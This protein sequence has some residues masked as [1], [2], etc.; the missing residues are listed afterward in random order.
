MAP[1]RNGARVCG[2]V[3]VHTCARGLCPSMSP[4]PLSRRTSC[5]PSAGRP[6]P[7]RSLTLRWPAGVAERSGVDAPSTGVAADRGVEGT[8]V[9]PVSVSGAVPAA[10]APAGCCCC[11]CCGCCGGCC[12]G[13]CGCCGCCCGCCGCCAP[14]AG[15]SAGA[16][17]AATS[18]ARRAAARLRRSEAMRSKM[19]RSVDSWISESETS[20]AFGSAVISGGMCHSRIEL[21]CARISC[22]C[23]RSH[24]RPGESAVRRIGC[25]PCRRRSASAA[26][27]LPSL[28][29]PPAPM[30]LLPLQKLLLL[31]KL[32]P[33]PLELPPHADG[34]S[35]IGAFLLAACEGRFGCIQLRAEGC[36]DV[37]DVGPG[38]P[39]KGDDRPGVGPLP[40]DPLATGACGSTDQSLTTAPKRAAVQTR[41]TTSTTRSPT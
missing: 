34:T 10:S 3:D 18:E 11:G 20:L 37:G 5:M 28:L 36:A 15:S 30:L 24:S 14:T 33:P 22:R 27:P 21:A 35:H 13:C 7:H 23:S 31:H 29:G 12:C 40:E 41:S 1:H 32:P 4:R 6:S 2:D 16:S 39:P 9:S 8:S 17:G 26:L 25:L 19:V 38:E